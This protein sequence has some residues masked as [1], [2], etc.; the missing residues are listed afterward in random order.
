[1]A[2][3]G[4]GSNLPR[5]GRSAIR[6]ERQRSL[7]RSCLGLHRLQGTFVTISLAEANQAISGALS[8]AVSISAH[9][10]VSVC[11]PDGHLVA[12]QRMDGAFAEA[13]W[14][15]IGKAIAAAQEGRPSG[16][17]LDRDNPFPATGLLTAMGAPNLRR[18]GGLPIFRQGKLQGAIGVS[19]A[20]SNDEDENCARAGIRFLGSE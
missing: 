10:S 13:S 20:S 12:H 2:P 4:F 1:M 6:E 5:N 7:S 11:A 15:S 18:P 3:D 16:E 19:G 17:P 8:H 14:R 9:V